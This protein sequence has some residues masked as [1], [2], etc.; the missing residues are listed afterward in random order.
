MS[1]DLLVQRKTNI[2]QKI[3]FFEISAL[4]DVYR[5]LWEQVNLGGE[6]RSGKDITPG[7]RI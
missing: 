2:K 3:T 1:W 4:I 5:V 6:L 7:S